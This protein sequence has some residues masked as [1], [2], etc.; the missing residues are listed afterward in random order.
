MSYTLGDFRS[1]RGG[2]AAESITASQDIA[3]YAANTA[4]TANTTNSGGPIT[5]IPTI[6]IKN[7]TNNSILLNKK[8]K[9]NT[10]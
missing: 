7:D 1:A 5:T 6:A 4:N 3:T 10:K 2:S 8:L 9:V